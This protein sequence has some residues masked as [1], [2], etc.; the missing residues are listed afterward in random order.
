MLR[1]LKA[2]RSLTTVLLLSTLGVLTLTRAFRDRTAEA[3]PPALI[4]GATARPQMRAGKLDTPYETASSR[5]NRKVSWARV[6]EDGNGFVEVRND[7]SRAELTID[8]AL[9]ARIERLLRSHGAPYASAVVLSV[10][11]G[12]ILAMAG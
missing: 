12:R 8:P 3:A 7:G 9:Q 2:R 10:E 5:A 6:R 1:Q 4:V 11:D